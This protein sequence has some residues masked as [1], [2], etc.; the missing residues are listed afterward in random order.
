MELNCDLHNGKASK[1]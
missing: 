1:P